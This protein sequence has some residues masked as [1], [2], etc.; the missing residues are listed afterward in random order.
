MSSHSI[1]PG[2]QRRVSSR[3]FF[4]HAIPTGV[5]VRSPCRGGSPY[6]A[7]DSGQRATVWLAPERSGIDP[8]CERGTVRASAVLDVGHTHDR[9]PTPNN[10]CPDNGKH[11]RAHCRKHMPATGDRT[12]AW[13]VPMAIRSAFTRSR[14][15]LAT[16]WAMS[17]SDWWASAAVPRHWRGTFALR[18]TDRVSNCVHRILLRPPD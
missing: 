3:S 18:T 7:C 12:R 10:F 5:R 9:S 15:K 8:L 13:R 16:V 17:R 2:R 14:S 1:G 4:V 6:S 11:I